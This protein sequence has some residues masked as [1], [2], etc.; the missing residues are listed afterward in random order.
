MRQMRC[1]RCGYD[2]AALDRTARACPHCGLSLPSPVPAAPRMTSPPPMAGG[3]PAD[4]GQVT[5]PT[6]AYSP[7][8]TASRPPAPSP[9][10]DAQT[11][12]TQRLPTVAASAPPT[13]LD[14]AIDGS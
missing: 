13:S 9:S 3:A 4:W 11:L 12:A 7:F 2:L 10:P 5:A 6:P 1:S 14:A 8:P